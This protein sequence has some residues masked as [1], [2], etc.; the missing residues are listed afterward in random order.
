MNKDVEAI[1]PL[2]GRTFRW[3]V[4]NLVVPLV[5]LLLSVLYLCIRG[6]KFSYYQVFGGPEFYLLLFMAV[7]TTT[8]EFH[9]LDIDFKAAPRY[10]SISWLLIS[11]SLVGA[12]SL[13][14]INAG[15]TESQLNGSFYNREL[16]ANISLILFPLVIIVCTLI[17]ALCIFK[18]SK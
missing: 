17:Q 7:F 12:L 4:I 6:I 18:T 11:L 8:L 1:L 10:R 13:G 15:F 9:F 16:V 2:I 5:I 3:L 14:Y